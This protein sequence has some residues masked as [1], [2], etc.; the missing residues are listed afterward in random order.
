M[1]HAYSWHPAW[2]ILTLCCTPLA[3]VIAAFAFSRTI[4]FDLVLCDRHSR[5]RKR[6]LMLAGVWVVTGVLILLGGTFGGRMGLPVPASVCIA[7]SGVISILMGP[8]FAQRVSGVLIA[9]RI[10]DHCAVLRGADRTYLESLPP[11]TG[12]TL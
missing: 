7:V 2:L 10:N 11:W 8:L 1:R 6:R 9:R 5:E 12:G 4:H 3:F